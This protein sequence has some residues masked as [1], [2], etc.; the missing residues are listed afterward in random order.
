MDSPNG[1]KEIT[2]KDT[3]FIPSFH[4]NV[5]ALRKFNKKGVYWDQ[6]NNTL[7]RKDQTFCYIQEQHKQWVLEYNPLDS[8][9]PAHSAKPKL[10]E[11]STNTWYKRYKHLNKEAIE[12]LSTAVTRAK[13]TIKD[14]PQSCKTCN[15]SNSKRQISRRPAVRASELFGKVNLDLIQFHKAY[16]EDQ[17][18]LHFLEDSIQLH[19]VYTMPDKG[20]AFQTVQDFVAFVKRQYNK[21]IKI[22]RV[23]RERSLSKQF[24]AW[25]NKL[26]IV[27]E[28]SAL[29]TP[30][31]NGAAER[32]RGVILARARLLQI[33]SQLPKN[34]WPEIVQTAA[35]LLNQSPTRQLQWKTL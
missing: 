14:I 29:Y 26:G 18:L 20:M 28:R 17:I 32:S 23:D 15:I 25:T 3:A 12:H 22:L 16:N 21:D 34:L 24:I 4:T 30:K 2:L 27:V 10:S 35:Y 19:Y 5:I 11:A 31:Q 7:I 6:I 8:A 9:F 33:S 13:V 1:P